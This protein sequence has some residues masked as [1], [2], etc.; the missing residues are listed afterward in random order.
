MNPVQ[1]A[2]QTF[3][4]EVGD[5]YFAPEYWTA[6]A[7]V[8][9]LFLL[10]LTLARLRH[11][12]ITWSMKGFIP[13]LLIGFLLAIILEGFLIIGGRTLFV[14]LIGWEN[15]PKPISNVL[16]ISRTKLVN[17]LGVNQEVPMSSVNQIMTS[18]E[19]LFLYESLDEKSA[20]EVYSSICSQ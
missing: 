13:I 10:V 3:E 16:D 12:Y 17:V 6:V 2:R 7:I 19:V 11:M 1:L 18:K 4:F 14:E 15:A 9:L 5:W 8:F 20:N